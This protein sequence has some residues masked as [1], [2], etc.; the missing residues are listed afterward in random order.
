M[1][2]RLTSGHIISAEQNAAAELVLL[3]RTLVLSMITFGT[4]RTKIQFGIVHLMV[5]T[6]FV[7]L[8]VHP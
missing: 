3:L 4:G 7:F 6:V 5:F 2:C 8:V 1:R